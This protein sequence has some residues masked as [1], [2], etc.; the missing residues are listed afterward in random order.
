MNRIALWFIR[1][2][3]FVVVLALP[4]AEARQSQQSDGDDPDLP[5]FSKGNID[6][7]EYLRLRS[8]HVALLRGLPYAPGDNPR[9][10]ALQQLDKM[11][12]SPGAQSMGL[13]SAWTPL[14]PSPLPNGQTEGFSASVTGRITTIAI[15]PVHPDTVYVGTAQGGVFRSFDGGA[16]WTAIFDNAVS[17]AI[18]A[19]A[20]DPV[21]N[22]TL[23]V[24]TGEGNL[25]LDSFFGVGVYIVRNA[26]TTPTLYGPYNLD[27]SSNNVL[28]YR[29]INKILVD[30][31]NDNII[32]V[33][34][35]SGLSGASG[36]VYPTK[37]NRGLYRSMN[38]MSGNP[39][40]TWLDM[41]AG[42]NTIITDAV[43]D[44]TNPNNLV[45]AVYGQ[46]G[47][48]SIGGIYQ[49]P[50]ALD[51]LPFFFQTQSM[52]DGLN[53][54]FGWNKV[55]SVFTIYA[56]SDDSG[57]SLIKSTDGGAGWSTML[58]AA[59]GF[60]YPQCWYDI[61]LAVDP[62]SANTVYICG[63]AA[64]YGGGASEFKMSTDGGA[65]FNNSYSG[66]HA[67]MHA[68]AI[69]NP[70]NNNIIYVGNDGGVFRST[71]SGNTWTSLNTAG[72]SATQFESIALHP[73]DRNFTIGGTQDNGTEYLHSNST[74]SLFDGGDGGFAL[75]DQ[76][77]TNTTTVTTYHTYYNSTNSQ[78]GFSM[79]QNMSS[80]GNFYG[81]GGTAN[82]INCG[83]ATLFYAP[84]ALG[85]GN[86]QTVYFGSDRLYR[87]VN[88]G[89]TM[90]VVSQA[91]F[92][93]SVPISAIGIAPL[94]DSIRVVGLSNGQVFL[95]TA[96]STSFVSVG[97]GVIPAHYIARI[98]IDP[99]NSNTAYVTLD[100]YGVPLS[101]L[102]HI[103]KTT[104]LTS[105]ATWASA[106]SGLPDVPVNA[107]VIDPANTSSVYAG[108]DIGV[109][110]S[111]DGGNSWNPF[112]TGLPRVAVFD[113][114]IQPTSRILRIATHGRGLW[115]IPAAP[116]NI[117]SIF[118][119]P[120]TSNW[121]LV[122]LPAQVLNDTVAALFPTRISNAFSYNGSSYQITPRMNVGQGYWVKFA[123]PINDSLLGYPVTS[124][125]I[126]VQAGWN[127]LGALSSPFSAS[128]ITSNP[129]AV[130]TSKFFGY[131]GAGY[132]ISDTLSPGKGYWVKVSQSGTLYLSSSS[133]APPGQDLNTARIRIVPTTEFPPAPPDV[134]SSGSAER[135]VAYD[136]G[137]SYPN[138]FNPTAT[139]RYDLPADSRV[140]LRVFNLLG[141]VVATLSDGIE[142]AGYR[143]VEWNAAPFASGIYFYQL[144]ATS[145]TDPN[146]SFTQV[147]KMMLLK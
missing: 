11:M 74:W 93:A 106:S 70:P 107:F 102:K 79:R 133:S 36:D 49:T 56:T 15:H 16:T 115:E 75:I 123:S 25:S 147:R 120:L 14:G 126:S 121:N 23:F 109:F 24:G 96:G 104:N 78:I 52:H 77:A 12:K 140:S 117:A 108:T 86:P 61:A 103:W 28:Q 59:K 35:T 131:N 45:A 5:S 38:A 31:L 51:S 73:S 62:Q 143:S 142:P 116:A 33:A 68:I 129:P 13:A 112:G 67:D 138:P 82:G 65:T 69:A 111:S 137:Q 6:R 22:T 63:S 136:L 92:V 50:D 91:P 100:G 101:P 43:L 1:C 3:L 46:V 2:M 83:D 34:S 19:I 125:S 135:P 21:D 39:T 99:Q 37:P 57:G 89:L 4:R 44:P 55:G 64:G 32:F 48:G 87:S 26:E 30:P 76:N 10:R 47:L 146:V 7:T 114:G 66:L 97:S 95:S 127:M 40:F 139:I 85:P 122:S 113:M 130:V 118:V 58:N 20:I 134:S 42:S 29:S 141:Q 124:E 71:T 84:M 9:L 98:A 81:C 8:E 18:G 105:G 144:E 72:L 132:Q 110:Y 128:S 60:C 119:E 41:S 94:N 88:R 90:S 17:L 145:V 27:G 54:K 53:V 80:F